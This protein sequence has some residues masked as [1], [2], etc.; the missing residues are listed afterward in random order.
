MGDLAGLALDHSVRLALTAAGVFLLVGLLTGVWKYQQIASSESATA[1]PY[2]DIAH[3]ASLLYSFASLVLAALAWFSMWSDVV[4]TVAVAAAVLFFALA[5]ATYLLH[6]WLADT[7]NQLQ[8]PHR[9]GARTLPA[10]ALHG[11]MVA[12]IVAEIGGAL[13][14]FIGAMRTLW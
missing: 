14:L 1:H 2:V 9:L 3:R 8:T 11:F 12:L 6:G 7:D 13:V 5:I 10:F 4:N